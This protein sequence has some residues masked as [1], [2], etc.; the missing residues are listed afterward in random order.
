MPIQ[1]SARFTTGTIAS[2]KG[3]NTRRPAPPGAAAV[4][5]TSSRSLPAWMRSS[6][7]PITVSAPPSVSRLAVLLFSACSPLGASLAALAPAGA[8]L[9]PGGRPPASSRT[10]SPTRSS[11][12][13]S[14]GSRGGRSAA[15]TSSSWPTKASAA[16]RLSMPAM[17]TTNSSLPGSWRPLRSSTGWAGL[18]LACNQR[19]PRRVKRSGKSERGSTRSSPPS[20]W[21]PTRRPTTSS[22]GGAAVTTPGAAAGWGETGSAMGRLR[23]G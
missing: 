15:G 4:R 20:P 18:P 13:N 8:P 2:T 19:G 22:S 17:R 23:R 10:S 12:W 16:S 11:K 3:M 1:P 21:A 6:T 7:R 5:S 9:A 14:P